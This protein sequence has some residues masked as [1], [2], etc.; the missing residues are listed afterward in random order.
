M[1]IITNNAY[2]TTTGI[3]PFFANKGYHSSISIY[4]EYNIAFSQAYKFAVNLNKS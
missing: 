4:S 2:S 1:V 3:F